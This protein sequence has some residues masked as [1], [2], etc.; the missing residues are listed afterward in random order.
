VFLLLCGL[1][2]VPQWLL[3]LNDEPES[4]AEHWTEAF[5]TLLSNASK[6][7]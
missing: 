3:M 5:N 1:F 6:E 7:P 4:T 2:C